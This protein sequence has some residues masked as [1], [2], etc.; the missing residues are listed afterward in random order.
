MLKWFKRSGR[1]VLVVD[2]KERVLFRT[3]TPGTKRLH[4]GQVEVD[5]EWLGARWRPHTQPDGSLVLK[6]RK[7]F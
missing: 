5:A 7:G 1:V 3:R 4:V 2:G 6:P